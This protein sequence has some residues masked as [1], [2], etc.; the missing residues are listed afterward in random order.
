MLHTQFAGEVLLGR[1][2]TG[3]SA[4]GFFRNHG[5]DVVLCMLHEFRV[6]V[7][8]GLGGCQPFG[9]KDQLLKLYFRLGFIPASLIGKGSTSGGVCRLCGSVALAEYVAILQAGHFVCQGR[10]TGLG[11]S[12]GMPRCLP[13][14]LVEGQRGVLPN[15]WF[16]GTLGRLP[17]G[18]SGRLHRGTKPA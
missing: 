6:F 10:L 17:E 15:E 2:Y 12:V 7:H 18:F 5:E 1:V 16:A 3:N 9:V 11:F 13:I 14:F 8:P 4:L